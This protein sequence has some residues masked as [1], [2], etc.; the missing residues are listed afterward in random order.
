MEIMEIRENLI[1]KCDLAKEAGKYLSAS[2]AEIRDQA[3]R[4]MAGILKENS[5]AILEANKKDIE[6]AQNNGIKKSMIDRLLL[7]EERIFAISDSLDKVAGLPDP[8]GG[9]DV[10]TRPNGLEIKRIHVPIG[11]IA[12]I[13][14]ARPNVTADASAL[15]IKS[16][17][18]VILRVGS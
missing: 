7:T 15:C 13:Y 1:K 4:R 14:E 9:G 8:L 16:G 10:W 17:N 3:I 2:D 6:S 11:H 18:T 5:A 12:I